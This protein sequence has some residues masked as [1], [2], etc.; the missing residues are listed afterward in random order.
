VVN[1]G[2]VEIGFGAGCC[3]DEIVWCLKGVWRRRKILPT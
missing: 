2:K 1:P 3:V